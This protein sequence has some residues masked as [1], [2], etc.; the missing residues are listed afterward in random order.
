MP[1]R[2]TGPSKDPEVEQAS[3]AG[4]KPRSI[5][6]FATNGAGARSRA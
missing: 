3:S 6:F 4:T 5:A 2:E 1:V